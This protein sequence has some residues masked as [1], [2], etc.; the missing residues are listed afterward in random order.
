M[1]FNKLW[2]ALFILVSLT[3][4]NDGDSGFPKQADQLTD[5]S[6]VLISPASTSLPI[7]LSQQ[8][9][10]EIHTLDGRVV[11]VTQVR[12]VNW[13]SD[14]ES[15]ATVSNDDEN[16][17][18]I[19][20]HS[21]GKVTITVSGIDNGQLIIGTAQI[22]ITDLIVT[23]LQVTPYDATTPIGL[24]SSLIAE[25]T[26]SNGQVIDVTQNDAITW[27]SGDTALAT[28]SNDGSNKGNVTGVREGTVAITASG[29]ANGQSFNET[30]DVEITNTTV[31]QLNVDVAEEVLPIG[32]AVNFSAIAIL[33][34]DEIRNVTDNDAIIWRSSDTSIAKVDNRRPNKG[35]VTG[36]ASGIVTITASGEANNQLF[37]DS[38]KIEV[39]DP[40]V[41]TLR[42]TQESVSLA[43]GLT[44]NL[45]AEA[46][47]SDGQI[48]DVTQNSVLSWS[49]S[50]ESI[51]IMSN[52][53]IEKGKIRGILPGLVTITASGNTN[54]HLFSDTI[55]VEVTNTAITQLT[56]AAPNPSLPKGLNLYLTAQAVLSNG[57]R[58]DITQNDALSWS[59]SDVAI[60]S[61]SNNRTEKGMVT[62]LTSGTVTLTA[63][64]IANGY[65]FSDTIQIDITEPVL[66]KVEIN[67]SAITITEYFGTQLQALATYSDGTSYD[68][69]N[70]CQ[71]HSESAE[72]SG[73]IVADLSVMT[74]YIQ[75]ANFIE[76]KTDKVKVAYL[77]LESD[78]VSVTMVTAQKSLI[79]GQPTAYTNEILSDLHNEIR[80][81]GGS[82]ID[83]IYD[84]ETGEL[85]AGGYGGGISEEDREVYY[86]DQMVIKDVTYIRGI[87]GTQWSPSNTPILQILEWDDGTYKKIG[88][89]ENGNS[90]ETFIPD[91]IL[92]I[93]VYTRSPQQ[94]S[95]VS[96]I[97]F[98]YK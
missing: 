3:A 8:L 63:S 13:S 47:M 34:D 92:G 62:G 85:L 41:S 66:Q 16:K 54:G 43:A 57:Q 22:E 11:N 46:T 87:S 9:T 65:A 28:V 96:A 51:A 94:P 21:Q 64:G 29:M 91:S 70:D 42:I 39:T 38:I 56:V 1:I 58:L 20:G 61:V 52:N 44:Q 78:P 19:T 25:V 77:G 23:Q 80:F 72:L 90:I 36:I 5:T 2:G 33:S 76:G 30:V 93:I 86:S 14:D 12:D 60:A 32:L 17:G 89:L 26:L 82:T 27:N 24:T 55:Q 68:V 40:V 49:S 35:I 97:Q 7:G 79:I 73:L 15:I 74:G 88:K 98:I 37:T 83:G 45:Y 71:W 69:T 18:K 95:H 4:C 84:A 59:S 81:Q 10:A 67:A 6:H 50:D 31:N 53:K 75:V 48:L